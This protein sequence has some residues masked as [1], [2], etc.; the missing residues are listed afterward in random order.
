MLIRIVYHF[1]DSRRL[2]WIK[3]RAFSNEMAQF[4]LLFSS[5]RRPSSCNQLNHRTRIQLNHFFAIN[6]SF[7]HSLLPLSRLPPSWCLLIVVMKNIWSAVRIL[8]TQR[9]SE[10]RSEESWVH[11][12]SFIFITVLKHSHSLVYS[13][14]LFYFIIHFFCARLHITLNDDES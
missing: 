2:N 14:F 5:S 11:K 3:E 4:A 12:Q 6:I 7:L 8:R 1:Y 10:E 13:A 9:T